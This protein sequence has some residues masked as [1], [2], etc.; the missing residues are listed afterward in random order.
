MNLSSRGPRLRRGPSHAARDLGRQDGSCSG[1]SPSLCPLEGCLGGL[2]RPRALS[3][4]SPSTP[5]RD[6]LRAGSPKRA[7]RCGVLREF[8]REFAA[9]S[10]IT[11]ASWHPLPTTLAAD[12]TLVCNNLLDRAIAR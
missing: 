3:D 4:L 12:T 2:E 1:R 10:H 6:P 11:P 9:V 7:E 5:Q 8:W